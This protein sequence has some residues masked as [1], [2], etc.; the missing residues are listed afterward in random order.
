M[1]H[2]PYAGG[3]AEMLNE[4]WGMENSESG[5]VSHYELSAAGRM[6]DRNAW[7]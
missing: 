5:S 6:V 4:C 2:A 7:L 3:Y 1:S